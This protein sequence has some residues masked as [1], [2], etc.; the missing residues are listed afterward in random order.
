MLRGTLPYIISKL[1][2]LSTMKE[3]EQIQAIIT[4]T[5]LHTHS[6]VLAKLISFSSLSPSGS[7]THAQAIF[8]E[9]PME[10]PFICN[11]MIRAY[12]KSVFPIKAIHIY[13]HMHRMQVECDN[14]TYTFAVK[15]CGRV[16]W[17][18]EKD[19][20]CDEFGI[21]CKG[22]EIHC[23]VF[24]CGFDCDHF[25]Q[26]SLVYMYS[27]CGLVGLARGVF[28][29]MTVRNVASWNIMVSAYDQVNDFK[30]ADL[31]FESM[32]V[33]NVVSSNTLIARFIRLSDIEGARRVF[34]EMPERDA[35]SWN[36][37]IAGYVKV[38]DYAGALKLFGEMQ[39]DGVEATEITLTSVL[40]ACAETGALEMGRKIHESL[41]QK[42][43]KIEGY[44]VSALVDMYAK[45]G[46]LSSALE[47]FNELKMKHASNWNAMIVGLA[48][49]GY[50]EEA[51][52]LFSAMERGLMRLG[53]TGLRSLVF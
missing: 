16:L 50:C 12:S 36:S 15:A 17:C 33:K 41:K 3:V 37:L 49:H 9:T 6:Y 4:K 30:S 44:L 35:V 29:E 43:Y 22:G 1:Q 2:Q 51:L 52:E 45:C 48:V 46:N 26:N 19:V 27:Q 47:V 11:T 7:L 20:G 32:P 13:N 21:A 34:E 10:N 28:D 31:L 53:L 42:G 14:F 23:S 5:G 24:K 8:Q 25:I 40:G 18:L 38:R 39:I